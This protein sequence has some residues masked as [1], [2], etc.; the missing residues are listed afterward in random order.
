SSSCCWRIQNKIY[1]DSVDNAIFDEIFQRVVTARKI[2]A[3]PGSAEHLR[4]LCVRFG[5]TG[6]RA[7]YPN[8]VCNIISSICRYESRPLRITPRDLDRAA[9][10]YFTQAQDSGVL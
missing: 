10:L 4:N 3:D 2:P 9:Q 6:L 7:C 5:T 8:D 1:V